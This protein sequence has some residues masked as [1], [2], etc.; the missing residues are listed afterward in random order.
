MILGVAGH[1]DHGKTALVKA[2][3][4]IETDRLPE[5]KKRGMTLELGFAHLS[6]P[7]GRQVS[8]IDMPGH[9]RFVKAMAAGAGGIDA[10]LLAIAA[11]ASVMPQTR[12]HFDIC[13]LLGV[14]RGAV[15]ITKADLLPG[16]GD[17]W[18]SLLAHDIS[19]L[20]EGSFLEAAKCL[21][22]SAKQSLGLEA[23]GEEIAVLFSDSTESPSAGGPF[24][25]PIDRV[26]TVKGFGC[27]VT[28]TVHSGHLAR[29]DAVT[30]VPGDEAA[31]AGLRVRGL[32]MHGREVALVKAGT[33]AAVNVSGLEAGQLHRGM[34]LI[35]A[36]QL[37]GVRSLDVELTWLASNARALPRRSRQ[38]IS[39]GA[40]H[41]EVVLKLIDSE[42]LA[43]G[44]TGFAQLR[45]GRP[46]AALAGQRFIV[47]GTQSVAGRGV[48]AGGGK[49]LAVNT[50]R[51][52]RG[53]DAA[54]GQLTSDDI[55]ARVRWLLAEAG[56]LG[57]TEAQ[58][59]SRGAHS[60]KA[61][62]R[63]L[64]LLA[65]RGQAIL[66]DSERRWLGGAVMESLR[67]R[68]IARLEAFHAATP[69][70]AS[71]SREELRQRLGLLHERVFAKVIEGLAGSK[72]IDV[73]NEF[74]QLAG[75]G[76][77]IDSLFSGDE[78][79]VLAVYKAMGLAP[80]STD[81]MAAR[82]GLAVELAHN[83]VSLLLRKG[84]LVR[85][86][87]LVFDADAVAALEK[88]VLAFFDSNLSM[89]TTQFKELTGQ[90]RKYA[91]PLA[92]YFDAKQVTL[93]AGDM[94]KRRGR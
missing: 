3:T 2:L 29:G 32:Q 88:R 69:G 26:F 56:P 40:M 46:I 23:L 66:V 24:F 44:E 79:R 71:I 50:R 93:R 57:L 31:G 22:V 61:V 85:A 53:D 12:E 45:L 20:V 91:M 87:S 70:G 89:S 65:T 35:R 52:R 72:I 30:L 38:L 92:E 76:Q 42:R 51:R 74:V 94:R 4:G 84:A 27:V 68:A 80:V 39:A 21:E 28:G 10:V 55:C 15:V 14:K 8:V 47:R 34:A 73:K 86:G 16:L 19:T 7:D 63:T 11:D 6:L 48:T 18:R 60:M 17:D 41:T 33:S 49:V 78:A 62:T 75:R 77:R 83:L 25:M 64:E 5:E 90:S 37:T 59:F 36:G 82:A 1:V 9:E 43:P 81:L 67:H 58:L 13:R 54:L